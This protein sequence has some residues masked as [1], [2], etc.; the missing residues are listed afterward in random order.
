M[1]R[2]HDTHRLTAEDGQSAVELA[3]VLPLLLVLVLGAIQL[4]IVFNRYETITD[5]ARAGARQAIVARL[6]GGDTTAARET[7]ERA[8]DSL[9][10]D[11]LDIQIESPNWATSGS[12]VTVTL[13]YPYEVSLL[14]WVVKS[15]DLTSTMKESLE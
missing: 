7:I 15:G 4:G 11:K 3:L 5:A 10:L 8:A 9:D 2:R 12:E 14:G 1:S 6:N 13:T